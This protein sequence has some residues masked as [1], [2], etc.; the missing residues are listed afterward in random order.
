MKCS[1]NFAE[2]VGYVASLD[3]FHR[4]IRSANL[5][6]SDSRD[7]GRDQDVPPPACPRWFVSKNYDCE[8]VRISKL[9]VECRK[10]V[11]NG[12]SGL[13]DTSEDQYQVSLSTI[14]GESNGITGS[15]DQSVVPY[16]NAFGWW[17]SFDVATRAF[18]L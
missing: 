11:C 8:R 13:P 3:E 7:V 14:I 15:I 4:S 10:L 18:K 12:F 17:C 1:A 5:F 2:A 9:R 6:M 16:T